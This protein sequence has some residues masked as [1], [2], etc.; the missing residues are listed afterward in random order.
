MNKILVAGGTGFVGRALITH[1]LKCGY[2]LH[3][4]NR[5]KE[6]STAENLFYF[7]WDITQGII[8]EKAFEGVTKIINLTGANIG[9]K[10]WKKKRKKE[11]I[12]SRTNAIYL[13]HSFVAKLQ[14]PIDTF[15]SS[16]AVGYYG[17]ITSPTLFTETS[18]NGNDYLAEVCKQWESATQ[19][20]ANLGIRTVILRKG[21]VLSRTGGMLKKVIPLAK[22][23][24][25]VALGNGKQYMPWIAL[26]DVVR[27]YEWMLD[28]HE[29]DG[30]YNV[31]SSEYITMNDFSKALLQSF[32]K[33]KFLPNMPSF[34]IKLLFGE[35]AAMLLEGSR[36]S[37][38]K[39]TGI[40]FQLEYNNLVK[41]LSR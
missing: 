22:I 18:S 9:E 21:I 12:D 29:I 32:G 34:V 11:I 23:G 24:L 2:S 8:D 33:K 36:V 20:F 16:S 7:K 39:L 38:E 26:Q 1:L 19:A 15:I 6:L 27:L 17:A 13:L 14:V 35:M 31:V 4:L 30:V 5:E 25:N 28:A 37:N 10:R 40:G 3:V 41:A